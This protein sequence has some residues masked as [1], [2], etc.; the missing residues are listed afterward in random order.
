LVFEFGEFG[1]CG[2]F[3]GQRVE[4][5][6]DQVLLGAVVQVAFDASALIIGGQLPTS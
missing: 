1:G 4:R 3:R 6:G 5:Q 2:G